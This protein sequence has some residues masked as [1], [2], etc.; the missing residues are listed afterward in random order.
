MDC[1]R[2]ELKGTNLLRSIRWVYFL[3]I[4][5]FCVCLIG[6]GF[7]AMASPFAML[8]T[9]ILLADFPISITTYFL[10]ETPWLA[11]A[12]VFVAGTLWWYLLSRIAIALYYRLSHR[13][14]TQI[15]GSNPD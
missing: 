10:S 6:L 5:H 12:W 15:L 3:P 1:D 8:W 14:K 11:I 9:F 4:L 7:L 2:M 13:Q